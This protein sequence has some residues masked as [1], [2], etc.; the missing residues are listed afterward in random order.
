M[1]TDMTH[2][3]I[4][5]VVGGLELIILR[6]SLV[7]LH[8]RLR[9]LVGVLGPLLLATL[10]LPKLTIDQIPA[11][12]RSQTINTLFGDHFARDRIL[13]C[14]C[15]WLRRHVSMEE[16]WVAMTSNVAERCDVSE[17]GRRTKESL[18]QK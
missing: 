1:F 3:G 18:H 6:H 5:I 9:G 15:S 16:M 8:S 14:P 17:R 7:C 13:V 12:T 11:L 2:V 10:E 4:K